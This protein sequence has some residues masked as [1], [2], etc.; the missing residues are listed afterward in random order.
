MNIKPSGS[1]QYAVSELCDK[2]SRAWFAISN[3][4]YKNKRLPVARAFQLFDSLIRPIALYGCEFWLPHILSKKSFDSKENL[5][6]FWENLPCEILNQKLCRL[7]LSVHKRC[8]RLAAIGELGR[9]PLFISSLKLCLKYE[10]QLSNAN[11]NSIVCKA[12][13]EMAALPQLDTWLSRVKKMK[14]LIGTP[15]LYGCKDSVS[16]Q[17]NKKL[18]SVFDRFWLDQINA[19]KLGA[20]GLDHNKLRFYKTL[21]GSFTQEPYI[22]KIQNRS[23]RSWL[24]RYR[25]SAVPNL[26]LESGRYTRPVTPVSERLCRYCPDSCIDDEQHAILICGTFTIKR[27]CFLGKIS[28]LLPNFHQLSLNNK[29]ISV[30]CPANADV[31]LCVSKYLGI[32]TETRKKLDNGLSTDMLNRYCEI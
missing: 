26:R 11:P 10:W 21:K 1:M 2:A 19:P 5:I 25:V 17:L 28:S 16:K 30:L 15:R 13:K 9:Y 32:I 14:S 20:D 3:V 12:V 4:L 8:S 22:T 29:L 27:N 24:T 23:Q 7:L 31:A 6:K 18:N